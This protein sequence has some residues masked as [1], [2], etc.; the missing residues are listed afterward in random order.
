MKYKYINYRKNIEDEISMNKPSDHTG[1]AVFSTE[2]SFQN[3]IRSLFSS[4]EKTTILHMEFWTQLC[5]DVP[6]LG[7]LNENGVHIFA[8]IQ[9]VEENWNRL[10]KIAG[11]SISKPMRIY[12]KYLLDVLN[13]KEEG[14][15]LLNQVQNLNAHMN[16]NQIDYV[17]ESLPFIFLSTEPVN[18]KFFYYM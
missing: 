13:N 9:E 3:E 17:N 12:A 11:S 4:I 1:G 6:D 2:F 7:K 10:K 18:H 5:E 8:S 16:S 14:E 15:A